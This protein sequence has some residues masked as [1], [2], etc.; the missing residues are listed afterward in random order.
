MRQCCLV[1]ILAHLLSDG[2]EGSSLRAGLSEAGYDMGPIVEGFNELRD[3]Q[4]MEIHGAPTDVV[5]DRVG[6]LIRQLVSLGQALSVFAVPHCCNNPWCVNTS[7]AS[8]KAVVCGVSCLCAGCKVARYCCKQC[9]ESHWR[10]A[11]KP[12]CKMLRARSGT[13]GQA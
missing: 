3:S 8:E 4:V 12:V 1:P 2:E 9:Q 11:H 10:G 7:G 5:V 13:Q 6:G